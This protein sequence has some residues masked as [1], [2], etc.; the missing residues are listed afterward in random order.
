MLMCRR[1]SAALAM[2][3][4]FGVL[5]G[6]GDAPSENSQVAPE[7]AKGAA[8]PKLAKLSSQMVSAVSSGKAASVISVHFVLGAPPTV[9]KP[10]PVNI[11]IVPH[12]KF[13]S[14][15][16][17]F[18]THDGLTVTAGDVYGP[19]DAVDSET[20]LE[21]ELM[22]SPEKEGVFMV[23]TIVDTEGD[24]GSITRIFSIP[25]IVS[26]AEGPVVVPSPTATAPAA[27]EK[28]A[29]N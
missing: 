17:H 14:V 16:A 28:P 1:F 12:R 2:I 10:L 18:E 5:A 19:K 20:A 26:P 7:P 22:L 15:R 4:C 13:L 9:G 29:A 6:C 3:A 21:H 27:V 23:T 24:E 25:V 11:A 8:A